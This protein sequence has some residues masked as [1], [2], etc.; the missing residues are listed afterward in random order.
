VTRQM[1]TKSTLGALI[2][3]TL[4]WTKLANCAGADPDLFFPERGESTLEAKAICRRCEVRPECL[5][6]AL[7][8][9]EKYG[10]WAGLS[11]RER[12]RMRRQRKV[13]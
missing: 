5:E 7:A 3:G 10:V 13:A 2:D 12:R 6:Y 8:A 4:E 1:V 11:E 9:G